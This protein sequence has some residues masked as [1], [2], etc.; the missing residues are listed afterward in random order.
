MKVLS[1]KFSKTML[2]I[3]IVAVLSWTHTILETMD[4]PLSRQVDKVA[5]AVESEDWDTARTEVIELREQFERKRWIL[6][7]FGPV[8]HV[9][10][11][12]YHIISSI[13]AIDG[14]QDIESKQLLA[15]IKGR[16]NEFII[17]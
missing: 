3:L 1:S 14:E 11:T 6:E 7:F 2:T 10:V 17:F 15:K 4:N 16:L 8:E 12:R 9:S 5:A 13:Q